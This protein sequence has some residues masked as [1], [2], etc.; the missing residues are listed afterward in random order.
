MLHPI[1]RNTK[2]G[3]RHWQVYIDAVLARRSKPA[4][5]EAEAEW[6]AVQPRAKTLIEIYL[7]KAFRK[8]GEHEEA[9]TRLSKAI[10][11][12]DCSDATIII[13]AQ[14]MIALKR[15][16]EADKILRDVTGNTD[17]QTTQINQL[18]KKIRAALG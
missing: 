12:P 4:L 15:F 13:C 2:K 5:L 10:A 16:Q 14:S 3:T 17:W 18:K 6:L 7:G 9:V 11:D 8:L 1:C